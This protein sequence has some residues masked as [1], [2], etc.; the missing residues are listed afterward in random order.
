MLMMVVLAG[1]TRGTEEQPS[2]PVPEIAGAQ[3][4]EAF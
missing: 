4:H 3:M 2:V 1:V